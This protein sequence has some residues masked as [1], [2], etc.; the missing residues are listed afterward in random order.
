VAETPL[1]VEQVVARA[2]RYHREERLHWSAQRLADEVEKLGGSLFRQAISKIEVGKRG[3]SIDELMYLA[4]AMKVSPTLLLF[5]ELTVDDSIPDHVDAG[6]QV[7]HMTDA[8]KWF[9]AEES[10]AVNET[11]EWV[12]PVWLRRRNDAA[13]IE[14]IHATAD[15]LFTSED[16]D[17]EQLQARYEETLFRWREIRAEIRRHG[18]EPPPPPKGMEYVDQVRHV[19]L[20]AERAEE[21]LRENPGAL[22]EV[23]ASRP[24]RGRVLRPGEPTRRQAALEQGVRLAEEFNRTHQP[25]PG[26]DDDEDRP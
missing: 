22:R 9:A 6:G 8:A 4:R 26:A 1:T 13:T 3:V 19:P 2:I 7:V 14:H 25:P 24:G 10:F 18:M 15:R 21:I 23:D 20:S 11:K 5:P 12:L 17:P 16:P